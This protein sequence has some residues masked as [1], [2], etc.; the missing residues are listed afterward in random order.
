M[1]VW[2]T[3]SEKMLFDARIFK[4]FSVRRESPSTQKQADFDVIKCSNWVNIVAVTNDQKFIF[5]KQY[6]HGVNGLTWEIPGGAIDFGEED[7]AAAKRELLEETGHTAKEWADLGSVSPNPSFMGNYCRTYLA[8]GAELTHEQSLDPFE[9][10]EV[11]LFE[12]EEVGDLVT[13]EESNHALVIA[14]F[15]L[16]E[17]YLK[18][19]GPS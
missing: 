16:Y 2:K 11:D 3:M 6:R 1:T 9:E 5:I 8:L 13:K 19:Q 17:Q 18:R 10:I 14:A 7:L 15:Y 12:Y 4:Y